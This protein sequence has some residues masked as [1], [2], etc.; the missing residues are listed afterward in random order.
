MNENTTC[1]RQ[2]VLHA[3]STRTTADLPVSTNAPPASARTTQENPAKAATAS[4]AAA[5]SKTSQPGTISEAAVDGQKGVPPVG[6]PATESAKPTTVVDKAAADGK[7][8][9]GGSG[10]ASGGIGSKQAAPSPTA[11]VATQRPAAAANTSSASAKK[12]NKG[13]L[14][15]M[16]E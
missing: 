4:S 6:K 9:G 10:A 11:G 7:Q 2:A 15:P 5:A 13:Q 3:E 1:S 14:C 16:Y 12:P 8:V